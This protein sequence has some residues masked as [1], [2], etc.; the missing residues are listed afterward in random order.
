LAQAFD[1]SSIKAGSGHFVIYQSSQWE[2]HQ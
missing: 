1:S 2:G